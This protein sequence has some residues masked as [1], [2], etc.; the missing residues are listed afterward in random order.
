MLLPIFSHNP[1]SCT[2]DIYTYI[3]YGL[4][5]LGTG[6]ATSVTNKTIEIFYQTPEQKASADEAAERSKF[7]D[8][9]NKFSQCVVAS[10]PESKK[11]NKDIPIECKELARI[12]VA[13]G[14][15]EELIK[16][17]T[18]LNELGD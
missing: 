9:R 13:C 4:I 14:G 17:I 8:A 2:D 1:L 12:F 3:T 11:N 18:D 15:K 6:I 5:S 10:K 16:I 7:I